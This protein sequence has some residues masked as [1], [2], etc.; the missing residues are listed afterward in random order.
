MKRKGVDKHEVDNEFVLFGKETIRFRHIGKRRK[1]GPVVG[2]M[3]FT[4]DTFGE[5]DN[6]SKAVS[7]WRRML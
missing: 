1:Q 5:G 3:A 4:V 7:F 6:F 2:L